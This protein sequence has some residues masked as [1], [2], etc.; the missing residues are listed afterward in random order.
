MSSTC[1]TAQTLSA[2]RDAVMGVLAS[3]PKS[4]SSLFTTD[5]SRSGDHVWSFMSIAVWSDTPTSTHQLLNR[6]WARIWLK[7]TWTAPDRCN[8]AS[9]EKIHV[10]PDE[11][12][13]GKQKELYYPFHLACSYIHV[14]IIDTKSLSLGF[15][16][17]K[18]QASL[19]NEQKQ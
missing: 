4:T 8:V 11:Q 15:P 17:R 13:T 18:V 14:M 1:S 9:V 10:F 2:G 5:L 16:K 12:W 6:L 3:S 7:F 19:N